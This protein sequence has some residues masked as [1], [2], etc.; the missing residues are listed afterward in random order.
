MKVEM[1]LSDIHFENFCLK[2][3]DGSCEYNHL[4]FPP[5]EQEQDWKVATWSINDFITYHK[6]F[7][8][9]NMSTAGFWLMIFQLINHIFDLRVESW[10]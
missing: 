2:L 5:K 10:V 6:S 1:T 3:I 4:S 8:S 7:Y 9:V